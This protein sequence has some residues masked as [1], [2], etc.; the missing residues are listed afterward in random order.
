MIGTL[1]QN[2]LD[3]NISMAS[4]KLDKGVRE[5]DYGWE[6]V[7]MVSLTCNPFI[8]KGTQNRKIIG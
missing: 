1:P 2:I 6:K 8:P 7:K 5:M 4:I 3:R